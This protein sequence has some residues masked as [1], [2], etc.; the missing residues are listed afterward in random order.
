MMPF[1]CSYRNK[2]VSKSFSSAILRFSL[3]ILFL[4]N[5][6]LLTSLETRRMFRRTSLR[7]PESRL[8]IDRFRRILLT[9]GLKDKAEAELADYSQEKLRVGN[10]KLSHVGCE[11]GVQVWKVVVQVRQDPLLQRE[12]HIRPRIVLAKTEAS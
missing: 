4:A 2:N 7:I 6:F 11:G 3:I 12:V 8:A 9:K 10:S 5:L 1:N